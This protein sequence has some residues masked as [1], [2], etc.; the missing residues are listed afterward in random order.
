[1]ASPKT[2][3][4]HFPGRRS[5]VV[6]DS[7]QYR[8]RLLCLPFAGGS[9]GAFRGWSEEL[10]RPH[11]DVCPFE[12][13]GH[14]VL[15]GEPPKR[16]VTSILDGLTDALSLLPEPELPIIVFG[17]SVG[18][19]LGFSFA[20]RDPR[21]CLLIAA[22]ARA[23]HL[24]TKIRSSLSTEQLMADLRRLGGTPPEVLAD[25]E[26]MDMFLPILRADFQINEESMASPD[27][28]I[29]VPIIALAALDDE[30]VPIEQIRPWSTHAKGERFR[31]VE[32]PDG[33]HFFMTSRRAN[34]L[35]VIRDGIARVIGG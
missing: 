34:V 10:A 6:D 24:P 7:R 18:G 33:G 32:Y 11:V 8:A 31:L 14:G 9:A 1:V 13:P 30:E 25:E 17:H 15:F 12:L 4:Q 5:A 35:D 27:A 29:D 20:Q 19:R 26:L 23:P 21:V 22:A 28:K 16:D 2:I 3:S